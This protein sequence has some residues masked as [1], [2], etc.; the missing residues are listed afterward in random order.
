MQGTSC[1]GLGFNIAMV[2]HL[3][4]VWYA[5]LSPESDLHSTS[6]APEKIDLSVVP[7]DYHNFTDIF[8]KRKADT[9]ASHHEHDLKINLECST[10]PLLEATYSLF[11]SKLSS[12]CEFLDKYLAMGFIHPS[13]SNHAALVLFVCKKDGSFYLYIH[14]LL[15][16]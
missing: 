7:P 9:L 10:F 3:T 1:P 14:Q 4:V 12:L 6:I 8:S 5:T 2:L 16:T 13:F 11:S 15:R